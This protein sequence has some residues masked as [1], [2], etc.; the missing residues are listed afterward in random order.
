MYND[1]W[2]QKFILK[3]NFHF[4]NVDMK[5]SNYMYTPIQNSVSKNTTY[6]IVKSNNINFR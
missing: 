4:L 2:G 3:V 1:F 6:N 5:P